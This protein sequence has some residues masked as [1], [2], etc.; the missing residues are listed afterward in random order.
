MTTRRRYRA[1]VAPQSR[2]GFE[3][4]TF[5]GADCNHVDKVVTETYSM[6]WFRAARSGLGSSSV[7]RHFPSVQAS[8]PRSPGAELGSPERREGGSR[9]SST[10]DH[11]DL[12]AAV[13]FCSLPGRS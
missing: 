8:G 7:G 11:I 9:H 1:A 6:K 13:Q 10:L 12:A 3:M 5:Q 4:R 2:I